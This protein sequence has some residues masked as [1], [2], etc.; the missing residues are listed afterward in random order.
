MKSKI[1]DY[2]DFEKANTLL[3]AFNRSTG[4]VTA[5]LDLDGNIL[6]KSGWRQ[7]CT[8]FHRVNTQTA[9]N[10][11]I[12][13]TKSAYKMGINEK[14]HFYTCMNGL[15]DVRIPIV[16]RGEHVANLYSGQFL[17]EK[18]DLAFFKEHAK[19]YGFDES[20][21]LE[22]LEKV[23][24][25][26]KD[27]V[28]IAMD[29]L[30][31]LIEMIIELTSDK[32][33]QTALNETIRKSEAALFNNQAQL[34]NYMDDLLES[35][36]VAHLGTWRL[37]L[38]TNEVVWSEELYK[39]YGFDPTIPPPPYTEHM[40]LFTPES[41]EKLSTSLER[42]STSGI[43]Y[44]LE[45][46]TVKIDGSN[47]WMW[48]RGEAVKDSNNKIVTLRGAAQDITARKQTERA[49]RE[50]EE[51]FQLLFNKAPLGY[52]SL[53]FDGRFIEVNQKWLETLGYS[54]EEVIGKWFGDFLCPEYVDG[55]LQRFPIFKAQGNIH[56]EFEMLS[57]SGQRLSMSFEG[58][59][60]YSAD[61]E[62]KQTHC[63]L[64]DI[65][66]QRI[67]EKVS[68]ENAF[69]FQSLFSEMSAGA[70]IYKVLNDG[71]YG[72][73]YIIQD[74][75]K[76]AL[77]AEGKAREEVLG[78]SLYDLRPNIDHYGLIPV[79]QEVWKTG[80]PAYFPSKI[81]VDEKFSNWY[82]NHIFKL[83]SGEIVAIFE[84]V[85]EKA[86]SEKVIRKQNDLFSSLLKLLPVG[87]LMVDATE[88]K[89]LVIND[90]G[91]ALLGSKIFPD[92]KE[93][94]LSEVYKAYKG[95]TQKQYPAA[96]M[97]I[98]LGMKGINSHI[99][100]MILERPDGSRIL[101]EVFGTPVNDI[102]GNPWASLVTFMD[103]TARKKN[104]NELVHLS[105]HDHLTGLYNRRFFE[106]ELNNLDTPGNLPLSIIMCDVNGLK[107]INDSFGH[108]SG[109]TLLKKAAETIKKV[110]RGEDIVARI[111][112][113]EFVLLLPKTS[114]HESVRI[115]NQI[116]E[117]ASKEKVANIE[118]SIS[119]GNATKTDEKQSIIEIIANA[120]NHMYRH[121]LYE[122]SSIRSKTIDLIMN[123][124]FE[125]S[126]REAAHSNRVSSFCQSIATEMKMNKDAV[127]QMKIA[128]L[129]HDIGKIGVNESILN[130][131]GSLTIDEKSDIEKHPEIGWRL[132]SSTNEFSELAQFVLNH[133]E[134][135][136]GCGY[137]NGLKGEE[138]QIEARIIAVADAYDA[139]TSERSY[140][141]A[142]SKKE[143]IKEL[144]K[145][146]GTQFDPG[147]VHVFVNQVLKV[148]DFNN[149]N[150]LEKEK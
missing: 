39:L 141:K 121:K 43:P 56:S 2:F 140:R 4:F 123:A 5:I 52:Q 83:P 12:S 67:A 14:Y 51:R 11:T 55:F 60:G 6:S 115:A 38:A 57:K 73:D 100:D 66:N 97:P 87:V 139:M 25:V 136:D 62:F 21:Y 48:V 107:L 111:G 131:P 46:E 44:E 27:K 138:I 40:K 146:S 10:C 125:K 110:C 84:D 96:E 17:F 126:S 33:E 89:P 103:I 65:T 9:L 28:E 91:K 36:R 8:D 20:L 149:F 144:M 69:R 72:K 22:A 58:T 124:L 35:Q 23:P 147:I 50:S 49:L 13:D 122:R 112:G 113:D 109:D 59:I 129:I 145:C 134:R 32:F 78:R 94:D 102:Q 120:E 150:D 30:L 143:S 76:A 116:K 68:K 92:A 26:S 75:N 142:L 37:D 98:T 70:A 42:T 64:Q 93:Y 41:W 85:T 82:E 77:K 105:V 81:Y 15:I 133:H 24:V 119:Y 99:D 130:K 95:D 101:L 114:A 19:T 45:L 79:F 29:F 132:L 61:G 90:M 74:F 1:L 127:N 106:Q 54:R 104:E 108:D 47:G 137:P 34:R 71:Q 88:G 86:L 63:I 80:E 16:I 18:P 135:W 31:H 128:G 7:I 148:E 118:L 53:D 117:L 3:E